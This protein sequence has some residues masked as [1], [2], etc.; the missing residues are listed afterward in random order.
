[1]LDNR[2]KM[3]YTVGA[4]MYS[5][6]INDK[7]SEMIIE[8]KVKGRYSLSLCLEDSISDDIVETA[9]E[10]VIKTFKEL[11]TYKKAARYK[12]RTATSSTNTSSFLV[13]IPAQ[14]HNTA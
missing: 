5:P 1:M 10:Q 12:Y 6:A 14:L 8:K 2:E 9:E 13:K 11:E 7:I 3:A 4:L